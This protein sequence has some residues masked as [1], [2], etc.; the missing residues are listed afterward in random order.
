MTS[1]MLDFKG[2]ANNAVFTARTL[3]FMTVGHNIHHHCNIIKEKYL[4]K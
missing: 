3:G 2:S 4:G 1:A